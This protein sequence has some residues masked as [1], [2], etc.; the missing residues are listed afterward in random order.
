MRVGGV[1]GAG[2]ALLALGSC[3]PPPEPELGAPTAGVFELELAD[4][5]CRMQAAAQRLD[6]A[7]VEETRPVTGG[8]ILTLRVTRHGETYPVRC[9]YTADTGD[10]VIT[11]L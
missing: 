11:S 5:A 7:E 2:A 10:A 8:A 4:E 1:L 6:V 3:T 9:T